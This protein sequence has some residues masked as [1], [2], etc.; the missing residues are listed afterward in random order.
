MLTRRMHS[1]ARD[2]GSRMASRLRRAA[3]LCLLMGGE[4]TVTVQGP[5]LGGRNQELAL[6][7]ALELEGLLVVA[8][9]ALTTD[10]IDG[11][12]DA[13]GAMVT[14]DPC[15][16]R[17]PSGCTWKRHCMP[18]TPTRCSMRLVR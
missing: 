9:M 12:T 13:T 10:G 1:E 14:G 5:G 8:V 17:A 15:R 16:G 6:A 18:T 4:T 2:V 11:P 3:G 7:A